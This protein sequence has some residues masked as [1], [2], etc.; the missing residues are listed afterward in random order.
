MQP[1]PL[2]LDTTPD[3]AARQMARW[4]AMSPAEK[5]ALVRELNL[6]LLGLERAGIR[7]RQPGITDQ[8]IARIVAD[9]RLGVELARRVHG[10]RDGA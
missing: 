6:S 7:L 3:I 5:L 9:R 2:S 10:P 1:P 4:R 8:E